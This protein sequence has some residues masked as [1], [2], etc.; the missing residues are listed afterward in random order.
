MGGKAVVRG[1]RQCRGKQHAKDVQSIS[2]G[3]MHDLGTKS[4]PDPKTASRPPANLGT[5]PG[6][7]WDCRERG[8]QPCKNTKFGAM[9]WMPLCKT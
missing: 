3:A 5:E 6:L 4:L 2:H 1:V 9:G 7:T 8:A